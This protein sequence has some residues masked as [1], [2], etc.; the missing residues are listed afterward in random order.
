MGIDCKHPQRAGA[1]GVARRRGLLLP[2]AAAL[3][4]AAG[5]AHAASPSDAGGSALDRLSYAVGGVES[6][7][8]SDPR[9]WRAEPDGPQGPMQVSAAAAADLGGGNRFDEDENRALGRAYLDRLYRHYGNWPD[10]VTAYNWGPGNMD[11]WIGDGRRPGRLPL[12]VMLYRLRVFSAALNGNGTSPRRLGVVHRQP[13]R[14]LADLRHPGRDTVAVER[15]YRTI[16]KASS[17][18]Q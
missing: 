17:G 1:A 4:A 11:A 9:M 6:S 2:I 13:R 8:G 15:L 18:P 12:G 10:A 5:V 7:H 14:P 3:L 16:L